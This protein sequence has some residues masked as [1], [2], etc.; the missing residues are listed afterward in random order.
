[1]EKEFYVVVKNDRLNGCVGMLK[2]GNNCYFDDYRTNERD[3]DLDIDIEEGQQIITDYLVKDLP[4]N[5]NDI[6]FMSKK[7]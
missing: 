7:I 4:C 3:V 5:P 6:H 1:M 2:G